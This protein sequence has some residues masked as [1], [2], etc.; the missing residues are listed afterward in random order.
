MT[1]A[2]PSS[3]TFMLF[4]LLLSELIGEAALTPTTDKPNNAD[5]RNFIV[6]L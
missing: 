4:D 3:L 5:T 1:A 2:P 6:V